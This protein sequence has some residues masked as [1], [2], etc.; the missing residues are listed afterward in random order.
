MQ[1]ITKGASF[2]DCGK[3]R[4]VLW[5][6]WNHDLPR[7]MVIGLN[8]STANAETD[9][10]TIKRVMSVAANNGYGGI[11]MTNCFPIVSSDPSVLPGFT[12]DIH[13]DNYVDDQWKRNTKELIATRQI[14]ADVVFAWGNFKIVRE[15]GQDKIL[16][17]SFPRALAFYINKNGSPKHPL[18]CK[19][20]T[21]F[22]PFKNN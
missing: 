7:L 15:S 14:C 9:D 11:Y 10:P 1:T 17:E 2:S 3:Y 8:P 19:S 4:F 5:R 22:V 16:S 6:I 18:Y 20:N 13:T 21:V 12:V